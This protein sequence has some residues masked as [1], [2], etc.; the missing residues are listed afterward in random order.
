[1]IKISDLNHHD[2]NRP[3]LHQHL[4]QNIVQINDTRWK[5]ILAYSG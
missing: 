3:T 2:L 5:H 1:M 4:T